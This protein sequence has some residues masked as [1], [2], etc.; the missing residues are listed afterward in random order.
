MK[1]KVWLLIIFIGLIHPYCSK[2]QQAEQKVLVT[3]QNGEEPVYSESFI[4]LSFTDQGLYL[5]TRSNNQFFV[6]ENGSR[7]GP[8][9]SPPAKSFTN[10]SANSGN[11]S[12]VKKSASADNIDKYVTVGDDGQMNIVYNG[13]TFTDFTQVT[14]LVV[15]DNGSKIAAIGLTPNWEPLFLTPDG[16]VIPLDGEVASLIISPSGSIAIVTMKGSKTKTLDDSQSQ[17]DNIQKMAEELQSVD[18][19]KM[20]PEQITAFNENLQ[21]KY[22][23]SNNNESSSPDFYMYLSSGKKIGP[24]KLGGYASDNPAFNITGGDN[25]YFI[26]ENKL[27]VNG[28][29]L[30]D[31]GDSSPSTNN[32]WLSPDGKRY[33]AFLNYEKLVFTDGQSF[34]SPLDIKS[35]IQNGKAYLTWLTYN[36]NKQIVLY[37][38]A[39]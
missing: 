30:K 16:K 4:P 26:D 39:L 28:T 3:L 7:K 37:N 18:F 21:K 36:S 13:K 27:Y 35:D 5:V 29:L 20:T 25:W 38:K 9:K 32:I 17:M 19:S 2:A 24:Y 10:N 23:L 1:K 22:G 6:Y 14:N 11:N 8:F 15:S 31:F 33:A 34:E 12:V